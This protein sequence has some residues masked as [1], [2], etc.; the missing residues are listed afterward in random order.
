MSKASWLV[1][2]RGNPKLFRCSTYFKM[3]TADATASKGAVASKTV[4]SPAHCNALV[5]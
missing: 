4:M 3:V 5:F 1:D 2:V